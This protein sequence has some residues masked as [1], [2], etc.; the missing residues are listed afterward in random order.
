VKPP[1]P[2]RPGDCPTRHGRAGC[3]WATRGTLACLA[4]SALLLP[5]RAPAAES[6][7]RQK[8]ERTAAALDLVYEASDAIDEALQLIEDGE[9]LE[10]DRLLNQAESHLDQA[11]RLDPELPRVPL[12]RA[13]LLQA[14]GDP[15]TAEQTLLL[16][17]RRPL[18][19]DE[20]FGAVDLLDG[21]RSDLGRPPISADW[22][23][24]QGTRNGGL[25]V[26][27]A[28][29]ATA[30]AGFG[31]AFSTVAED[32]Y[33]GQPSPP[34]ARRPG[35]VVAGVGGGIMLSGGIVLAFGE[36]RLARLRGILPGPWRHPPARDGA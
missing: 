30:L 35:F 34:A 36:G 22:R 8:T 31:A 9:Q 29:L 17:L 10:A 32:A 21:I 11:E 2:Q 25:L 23:R 33:A 28:G 5:S 3:P 4:L 1:D 24:A 12:Q 14:D 16:A 19:T 7:G 18:Q 26:L 15:E 20:H 6:R 27:G 13:R